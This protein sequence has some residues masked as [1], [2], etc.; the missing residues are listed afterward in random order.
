M[1]LCGLKILKIH[2]FPEILR[3]ALAYL[4]EILHMTLF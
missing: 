1:P 4:A 3:H 2:S